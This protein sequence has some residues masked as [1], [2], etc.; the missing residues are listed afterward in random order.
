[1]RPRASGAGF[2]SSTV[3]VGRSLDAPSGAEGRKRVVESTAVGCGDAAATKR[4]DGEL[5]RWV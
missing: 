5:R 3:V 1:M 4:D 2:V